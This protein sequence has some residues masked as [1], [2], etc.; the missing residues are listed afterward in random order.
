MD[1]VEE[2]AERQ[3]AHEAELLAK[4][5]T[6]FGAWRAERGLTVDEVAELAAVDPMA[7][8]ELESAYRLA[9]SDEITQLSIEALFGGKVGFKELF[10]EGW[11]PSRLTALSRAH[12]LA[13]RQ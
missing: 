1:A 8:C 7:I 5:R 10:G 11:H 9:P 12:Y 4:H 6:L 13:T 3:R 2:L